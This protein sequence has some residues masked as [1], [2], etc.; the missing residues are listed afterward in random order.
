MEFSKIWN[1]HIYILTLYHK[2]VA[3]QEAITM[4]F[5]HIECS[6]IHNSLQGTDKSYHNEI[7]I[8]TFGYHKVN[9]QII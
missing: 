9:N 5:I 2:D 3:K 1:L 7:N 8:G 4:G 6:M